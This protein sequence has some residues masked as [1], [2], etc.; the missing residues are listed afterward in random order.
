MKY[1]KIILLA[2]LAIAFYAQG[3]F[4]ENI[5]F[6]WS[7]HI[8]T[9]FTIIYGYIKLF[10]STNFSLSTAGRKLYAIFDLVITIGL[11]YFLF[12]I[13]YFDRYSGAESFLLIVALMSI[14][15]GK[16]IYYYWKE[17]SAQIVIDH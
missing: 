3:I 12:H 1:L 6:I 13:S 14:I 15:I 7:G 9:I 10:S 16:L 17:Y 4:S 2:M 11:F 8:S 5:V